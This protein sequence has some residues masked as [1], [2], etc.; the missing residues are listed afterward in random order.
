MIFKKKWVEIWEKVK[1]I[2]DFRKSRS[3]FDFFQKWLQPVERLR[4]SLKKTYKVKLCFM[5]KEISYFRWKKRLPI[6]ILK[7]A[8]LLFQ[9][10]FLKTKQFFLW[11]LPSNRIPISQTLSPIGRFRFLGWYYL[12]NYAPYLGDSSIQIVYRKF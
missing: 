2:F 12:R 11:E 1:I 8:L 7:I 5:Q 10:I 6:N 4:E 9:R 3:N